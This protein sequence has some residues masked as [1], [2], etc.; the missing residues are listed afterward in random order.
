M[1]GP[2][3]TAWMNNHILYKGWDEISYPFQNFNGCTVEVWDWICN[4]IPHFTEHV[5]LTNAGIK[6]IPC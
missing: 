2:Y 3:I 5:V 4:F 1:Q 6:V